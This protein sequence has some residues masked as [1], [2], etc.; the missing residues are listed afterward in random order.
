MISQKL[1][2]DVRKYLDNNYQDSFAQDREQ[3]IRAFYEESSDSRSS[4]QRMDSEPVYLWGDLFENLDESFSEML[5][6][7]ID[8]KGMTDVECYKKANIDRKVFSRIR[9]G[10]EYHP[11]KTTAV[12]FALALE[13]PLYQAKRLIELAGYSLTRNNKFDVIIEYFIVNQKYDIFEINEVL[14]EFNQK[15]LGC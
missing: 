11:S 8:E 6:R 1:L 3:N 13:L 14:Y 9:N 4:F 7:L 5:F 10:V 15:L 12:A 2:N